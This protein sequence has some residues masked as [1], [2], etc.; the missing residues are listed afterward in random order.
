MLLQRLQSK[1]EFSLSPLIKA[2]ASNYYFNFNIP[3]FIYIYFYFLSKICI[4]VYLKKKK[5]KILLKGTKTLKT[6]K[7]LIIEKKNY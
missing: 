1:A 3:Y 6:M 7:I 5:T 4:G 2:L